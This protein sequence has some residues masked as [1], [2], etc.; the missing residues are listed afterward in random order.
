[1]TTTSSPLADLKNTLDTQGLIAGLAFLNSRVPHRFTSVY[2]LSEQ[3]LQRLGFVDKQGGAGAELA[4]VP[5]KDS[6]CEMAVAEG[7][8][9]TFDSATD[10]RLNTKLNPALIGSYVGLPL[11]SGPGVLVGTFCHYDTCGRPL[12]ETEFAFLNE[13]S[14]L[15]GRFC[16]AVDLPDAA[17][18][19]P[20]A[21]AG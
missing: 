20:S 18:S 1:M 2:R 13:A 4:T 12:D 10:T 16:S 21:A 8:F 17:Q 3:F 7:H 6:F 11:S 19:K 14:L 15:L 9:V 5:F